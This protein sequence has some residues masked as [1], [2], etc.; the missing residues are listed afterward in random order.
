MLLR[1]RL[2]CKKYENASGKEVGSLCDQNNILAEVIIYDIIYNNGM[3]DLV[4]HPLIFFRAKKLYKQSHKT[5]GSSLR[6]YDV[7]NKSLSVS[8][9]SVYM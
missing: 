6:L 4:L 7:F 1:V 5:K 8:F 9:L 2:F 3:I